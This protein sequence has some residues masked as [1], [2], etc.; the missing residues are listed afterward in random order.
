M[1]ESFYENA[2]GMSLYREQLTELKQ[3]AYAV[4]TQFS[5]IEK[6]G[7]EMDGNYSDEEYYFIEVLDEELPATEQDM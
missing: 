7:K 4:Q 2:N 5:K 3:R 6:A 1:M